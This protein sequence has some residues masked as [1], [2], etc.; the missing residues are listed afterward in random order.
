MIY[1]MF[2][3]EVSYSSSYEKAD[4]LNNSLFWN[5]SI[6]SRIVVILWIK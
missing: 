3:N 5:Q 2:I 4:D 6:W 1:Y